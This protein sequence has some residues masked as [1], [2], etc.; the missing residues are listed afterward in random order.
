MIQ[1]VI[2]S[3]QGRRVRTMMRRVSRETDWFNLSVNESP[4]VTQVMKESL[5]E[6]CMPDLHSVVLVISLRTTNGESLDLEIWKLSLDDQVIDPSVSVRSQLYHRMSVMLRSVLCASRSTPVYRQ[7]AGRQASDS[8][9][10]CYQICTDPPPIEQL[11][12]EAKSCPLGCLSSPFGTLRLTLQFRTK[13]VINNGKTQDAPMPVMLGVQGKMMTDLRGVTDS[14][15]CGD[16]LG[17]SEVNR[18]LDS[19]Y[20]LAEP[21]FTSNAENFPVGCRLSCGETSA[22]QV[23]PFLTRASDSAEVSA[24][25]SCDSSCYRTDILSESLPPALSEFP[26]L[27]PSSPSMSIG[28]SQHADEAIFPAGSCS[29]PSIRDEEEEEEHTEY[30]TTVGALQIGSEK[31]ITYGVPTSELICSLTPKAYKLSVPCREDAKLCATVNS[32]L[33]M[34]TE[35]VVTYGAPT[36]ELICGLNPKA[37]KFD[38]PCREDVKLAPIGECSESELSTGED[39]LSDSASSTGSFVHVDRRQ[40]FAASSSASD[41]GAFYRE[42]RT[43]PACLD[44]FTGG[45]PFE[46][47]SDVKAPLTGA[48]STESI[49]AQ[50]NRFSQMQSSFDTFLESLKAD[51]EEEM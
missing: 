45:P 18:Q 46:L 36:S 32:P 16:P 31:V 15:S 24:A 10:L 51:E 41:L 20:P 14:L 5:G 29:H 43:A 11:G 38:S 28:I 44:S 19:W 22:P 47:G 42:F 12:E 3:R 48:S 13:M 40:V 27:P 8:F 4:E 50:L 9:V 1:I 2:E 49:E 35:R 34:A 6:R 21:V 23:T 33:A 37:C 30:G 17:E 26:A 39:S 7:Y 25:S